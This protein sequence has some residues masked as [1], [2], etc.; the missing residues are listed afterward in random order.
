MHASHMQTKTYIFD[1]FGVET[2]L[3]CGHTELTHLQELEEQLIHILQHTHISI[4]QDKHENACIIPLSP[5]GEARRARE[6]ARPSHGGTEGGG[7]NWNRFALNI[8]TTSGYTR[9]VTALGM[10][11]MNSIISVSAA[12]LIFFDYR[13]RADSM[14]D[15]N[16]WMHA[17]TYLEVAKG[18][19]EVKR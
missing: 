5:G 15:G 12:R 11:L 13:D 1:K 16:N 3:C 10:A 14:R 7:S 8:R 9:G 4:R 19:C 6:Q 17:M 18:V 2:G